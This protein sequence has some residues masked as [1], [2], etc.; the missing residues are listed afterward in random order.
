MSHH[1]DCEVSM[2]HSGATTGLQARPCSVD[3]KSRIKVASD[4]RGLSVGVVADVSKVVSC[5]RAASLSALTS[6]SAC[7]LEK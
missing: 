6:C 4:L 7:L 2:I 5:S 3:Q 1:A